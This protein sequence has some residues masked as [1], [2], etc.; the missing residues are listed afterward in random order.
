MESGA[1]QKVYLNIVEG[2][3]NRIYMGKTFKHGP[4]FQFSC[5]SRQVSDIVFPPGKW[6]QT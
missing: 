6:D 2:N 3:K 1:L 4:T 5:T